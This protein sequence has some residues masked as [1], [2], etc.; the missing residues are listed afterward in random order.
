MESYLSKDE[1]EAL[2]KS[3]LHVRSPFMICSVTRSMFSVARFSGGA[4]IKGCD[5]TYNPKTDEL[6][7][8]DVLKWITKYRKDQPTENQSSET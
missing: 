6:I 1:R 2:T 8:D 4:K 3:D 5:Y 7:R